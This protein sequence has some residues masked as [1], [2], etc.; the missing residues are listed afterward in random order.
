M[1]IFTQKRMK[2]KIFD[3]SRLKAVAGCFP[4]GVTVV[5]IQLSDGEILGMTASSFLSVSLSPPLVM[6]TV[7]KNNRLASHLTDGM[8]L[9]ISIL[10]EDMAAVSNHFARLS[11]MD[12]P[13]P[14]TLVDGAPIL[15]TCHA[16]YA[17]AVQNIIP[18]GDHYLVL[19]SVE[20]LESFPDESPLVYYRGY[21]KLTSS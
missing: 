4:T 5:G 1:R 7:I 18:A 8:A 13:P 15:N 19:C 10:S 16:W 21:A 12:T 6:F 14:F 3:P 2:E 9:G 17:T 11:T 20:A